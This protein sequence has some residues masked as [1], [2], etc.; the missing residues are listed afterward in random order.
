MPG[1]CLG[2]G[3]Q[4]ETE[5][6]GHLLWS[7]RVGGGVGR[8]WGMTGVEASGVVVVLSEQMDE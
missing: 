2:M 4:S 1:P 7:K 5:Q 3:I 6:N 8:R